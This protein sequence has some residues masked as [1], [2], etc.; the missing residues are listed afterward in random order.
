[1]YNALSQSMIISSECTKD[2]YGALETSNYKEEDER[3]VLKR[4]R[5][6][7]HVTASWSIK[8]SICCTKVCNLQYYELLG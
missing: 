4:G 7:L 3:I 2:R 6:L 5:L 1:M 8:V